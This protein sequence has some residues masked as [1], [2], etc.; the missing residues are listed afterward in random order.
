MLQGE[1]SA[2]LLTFIKLPFVIKIFVLSVFQWPFYTSFTVHVN[3][4]LLTSTDHIYVY[5]AYFHV[6]KPYILSFVYHI[7]LDARKPVFGVCEQQR[8]RP[9]CT[10]ARTGQHLC[11]L[12]IGKLSYLNLQ[13]A[14]FQ[15]LAS[16]CS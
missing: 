3:F 9:T 11:Y 15:F 7:S 8:R 16:N 2:I 13:Q 4:H 14:N 5:D 10:S 6:I 12:P 1:H